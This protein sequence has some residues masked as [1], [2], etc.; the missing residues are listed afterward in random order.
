M[1]VILTALLFFPTLSPNHPTLVLLCSNNFVPTCLNSLIKF[2][3]VS[4]TFFL[5]L[6]L[7]CI[8]KYFVGLPESLLA[9]S[10]LLYNSGIHLIP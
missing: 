7:Y 1:L 9:E 10:P 8:Y 6:K 5:I 4:L 2:D 3:F